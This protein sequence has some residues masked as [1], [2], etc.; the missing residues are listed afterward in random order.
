MHG[1]LRVYPLRGTCS[2]RSGVSI[3]AEVEAGLEE[4][5]F[6][7][8]IMAKNSLLAT[9]DMLAADGDFPW[10]DDAKRITCAM[11]LTAFQAKGGAVLALER[12]A[13][14]ASEGALQRTLFGYGAVPTPGRVQR[15]DL[16]ADDTFRVDIDD[17]TVLV[18][19]TGV[20]VQPGKGRATAPTVTPPRLRVELAGRSHEV[21]AKLDG[22][23]PAV[24][25]KLDPSEVLA[26][27][28]CEVARESVFART[29]ELI[30]ALGI[31]GAKR[32]FVLDDWEHPASADER[33][34]SSADLAAVCKAAEAGQAPKL[35][36]MP[37]GSPRFW[38]ADVAALRPDPALGWG[39]SWTGESTAAKKASAPVKKKSRA[40][41]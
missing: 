7:E 28:L 9:L 13:Y 41:K 6:Q 34:S 37:N 38:L 20:R 15:A 26:I 3:A 16:T 40:K 33:A 8:L 27:R 24:L 29:D 31:A 18:K 35:S 30:E 10:W 2:D 36:G 39:G 32:L 11:R 4:T 22:V 19:G 14:V 23:K 25:K 17:A 1:K 21:E 5:R 12:V